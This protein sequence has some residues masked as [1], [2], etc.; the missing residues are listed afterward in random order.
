MTPVVAPGIGTT[1]H[2]LT[3]L[4]DHLI[5]AGIVRDPS[6]AGSLPP[7]F[8]E[9]RNGVNAP[10]EGQGA[11]V[12]TTAVIGAFL[13]GGLAPGPYAAWA[14]NPIVEI[15]LRTAKGDIAYWLD[16]QISNTLIDRRDFILGGTGGL[17]LV[18]CQQVTA[19]QRLGSDAQSFD[20][21]TSYLFVTYRPGYQGPNP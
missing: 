3:A 18:E 13:A 19:L 11:Q 14:Q 21:V 4:K 5:A 7:M 15:R 20:Y 2:P 12:G 17:Y 8:L 1:V 16:L 9:P 6:T 10:G